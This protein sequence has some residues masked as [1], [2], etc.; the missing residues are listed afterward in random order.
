MNGCVRL[1]IVFS[2]VL[3]SGHIS[4]AGEHQGIQSR[5]SVGFGWERLYYEENEPDNQLSSNVKVNNLMVA[6]EGIKRWETLFVGAKTILPVLLFDEKETWESSGSVYQ[7]DSFE[8]QWIRAD[9][10]LGIFIYRLFNPYGGIRWSKAVHERSH[11]FENNKSV[12]REASETIQS[13]HAFLGVRGKGL[14]APQWQWQYGL[15]CFVPFNVEVTN[16][17]FPDFKATD[18][19]GYTLELHIGVDYTFNDLVSLGVR[20]YG[21]KMHWNGSQWKTFDGERIKWPENDTD[22]FGATL[23][24]I[25]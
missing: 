8:Y 9:G 6:V 11:F 21:G 10:F 7:T 13:W 25:W 15:E 22:Y 17:F 20:L 18:N 1:L 23:T 14:M 19:G 16:T 12:N 4:F 24:V 5:L 3:M 2:F